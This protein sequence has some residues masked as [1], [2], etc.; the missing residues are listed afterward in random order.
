M[1]APFRSSTVRAKPAGATGTNG[2]DAGLRAG[3]PPSGLAAVD[4]VVVIAIRA[5]TSA[6]AHARG[7]R[8]RHRTLLEVT[9][10]LHA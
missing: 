5:V 4:V 8:P 2:L 3:C 1:P 6:A 9:L 7:Q 10:Y